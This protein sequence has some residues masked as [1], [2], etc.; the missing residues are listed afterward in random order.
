[1][2]LK[3]LMPSLS[4]LITA[5]YKS[6]KTVESEKIIAN[7]LAG[8]KAV[9]SPE[10]RQ[11]SGIPGAGKSTYCQAHLPANFLFLSFDNIMITLSGYQQTLAQEGAVL[12]YQKYEMPAR[13]IGYE[14]LRRAIKKHY[15]IL[16]EHSGTNNAH[17]EMFKNLPKKGYKT[18][19]D[20]IVCDTKTAIKRTK[21]R[22]KKINRYVSEEVIKERAAGFM[23]YASIY[24]KITPKIKYLD[25]TNNFLPL[26]KI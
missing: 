19:V 5:D 17:I 12:A 14:V 21:E 13:I 16:F 23:K 3:T 6:V 24:Q 25:G 8:L 20:F 1:M 4:Q 15:N 22:A 2:M 18:S 26:N 9:E 11:I 10:L 7:M